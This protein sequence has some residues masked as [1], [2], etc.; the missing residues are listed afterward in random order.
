[1]LSWSD[2]TRGIAQG[3]ILGP[4]IFNIFI[5]D[6]FYVVKQCNLSSYAD[7]TNIVY[8]DTEVERTINSDLAL[9][10]KWYDL[11]GFHKRNN[12]KYQAIVMGKTS[13]KPTFR[14]KI[15]IIHITSHLQMLG[16]NIDDQ[17]KFDNYGVS[18]VSRKVSQQIAV[19]Y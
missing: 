7:D 11:N 9:V 8:A 12:S 1:M 4:L 5:N 19:R 3:S 2:V 18:K 6:L 14:C 17:L 13:N 15:T 16:D 10:D